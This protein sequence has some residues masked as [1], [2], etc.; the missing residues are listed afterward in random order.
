MMFKKDPKFEI[1]TLPDVDDLMDY[2]G[3]GE[4]E[5]D[6]IRKE[7]LTPVTLLKRLHT[8]F[9][10]HSLLNR[11]SESMF[12][13]AKKNEVPKMSNNANLSSTILGS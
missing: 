7:N 2:H 11:T 5:R 6:V 9:P 3:L 10:Q 12:A 13:N 8:V 4:H 1:N